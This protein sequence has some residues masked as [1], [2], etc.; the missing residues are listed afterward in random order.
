[1]PLPAARR[2]VR[3]QPR[4]HSAATA[5]QVI[6]FAPAMIMRWMATSWA[7]TEV[8]PD[9]SVTTVTSQLSPSAW[10]AGATH[11]SIH[12]PARMSCLR[13]VA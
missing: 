12:R 4:C 9:A 10:I 1:M 3:G 7:S 11:I 8:P 2:H 6:M 5:S 13:P